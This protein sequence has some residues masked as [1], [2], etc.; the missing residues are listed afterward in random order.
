MLYDLGKTK[1]HFLKTNVHVQ[2]LDVSKYLIHN[3]IFWEYFH[4]SNSKNYQKG[5][6]KKL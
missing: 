3:N 1:F 2:F 6:M 5:G 4:N